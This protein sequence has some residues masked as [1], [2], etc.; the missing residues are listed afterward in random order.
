MKIVIA[1]D[2]FKESLTAMQVAEAIERGF[3]QVFSDASFYKVPMADGGEGTVQAMIDATD[4]EKVFVEVH[5]PL[6][7]K[8]TAFYGLLGDKQTAVIEIAEASGLHLVPNEQRNP[9]ITC[10][11]GSG[12]LINHALAQGVKHIIIGLGGSATNDG[13]AGMLKALGIKL[14]DNKGQILPPGGEALKNLASIDTTAINP[15][16][17]QVKISVA[18]DVNNP[19]CGHL[20]ASYIFAPQKGASS[21]DVELLDQA[22][23]HYG[24]KLKQHCQQDILNIPGA[25][26]AGG[27]GAG[28]I[29]LLDAKLM[30]GIKLVS[31]TL[32]LAQTI[33][34]ADLVITG[35]GRIDQQTVYG[36]TPIG[37]A[38]I[39]QQHQCPVIAFCGSLGKG[40]SVV[41]QHGIDAVFP[42]IPAPMSLSEALNQGVENI[43]TT[44]RNVAAVL[45]L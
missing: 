39:A 4:G 37:V 1:P 35:E 3:K 43:T 18:C 31:Q 6:H 12:E 45:A 5:D 33:K 7:Q 26:A 38:Q 36:K 13:G 27:M 9:L 23:L 42:I 34:E 30:S 29:A 8:V 25:G 28:L 2:S 15:K 10:S 11:F 44:A 16:L 32:K 17:K 41:H 19:L 24:N 22:L 40:H 14:Y 21:K 20:G